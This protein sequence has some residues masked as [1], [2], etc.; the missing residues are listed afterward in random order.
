MSQHKMTTL[1]EEK[2]WKNPIIS[3]SAEMPLWCTWDTSQFFQLLLCC[4]EIRFL[5]FVSTEMILKQHAPQIHDCCNP[6]CVT[7]RVKELVALQISF[8]KKGRRKNFLRSFTVL[9]RNTWMTANNH[10]FWRIIWISRFS[11]KLMRRNGWA[12]YAP[13]GYSVSSNT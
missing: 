2:S 9:K 12:Q 10:R 11:T 3:S 13:R 8:S 7:T 6:R 1:K 5:C 4:S